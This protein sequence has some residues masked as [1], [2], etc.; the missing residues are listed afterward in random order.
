[1]IIEREGGA[2]VEEWVELANGC[3]VALLSIDHFRILLLYVGFLVKKRRGCEYV[4]PDHMLLETTGLANPAP[5]AS[6]LWLDDLLESAVKLDSII[7]RLA[8]LPMRISSIFGR[9]HE[10][11]SSTKFS[12]LCIEDQ[13]ITPFAAGLDL[14][15]RP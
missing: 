10:L 15:E 1:M 7:T 13:L 6:V 5:L 12:S 9:K 2:L 14:I 3:C 11:S 4:G 8:V